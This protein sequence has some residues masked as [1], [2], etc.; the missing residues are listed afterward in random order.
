MWLRTMN[1]TE[2][3]YLWYGSLYNH[4]YYTTMNFTIA[5]IG[6]EFHWYKNNSG[7]FVTHIYHTT[8]ND[9]LG[10]LN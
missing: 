6:G 4:A 5:L 10:S 9:I 3:S 8:G 7:F 2:I 1:D